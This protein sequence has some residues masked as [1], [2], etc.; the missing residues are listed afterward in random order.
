MEESKKIEKN[1]ETTKDGTKVTVATNRTKINRNTVVN[2]NNPNARQLEQN[3]NNM[4][5]G[6]SPNLKKYNDMQQKNMEK[7]NGNVFSLLR[8]QMNIAKEM[9]KDAKKNLPKLTN[10]INLPNNKQLLDYDEKNKNY[11]NN[12]NSMDSEAQISAINNLRD[13]TK[14]LRERLDK[15]GVPSYTEIKLNETVMKMRSYL[16][17]NVKN[18]KNNMKFKTYPPTQEELREKEKNA[19]MNIEDLSDK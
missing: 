17:E 8:G 9:E 1:N 7:N 19:G 6:M 15:D 3:V 12:I 16:L 2:K 18:E 14:E 13:T 10:N 11:I 4:L 5:D